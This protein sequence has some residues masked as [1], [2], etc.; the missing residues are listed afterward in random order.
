MRVRY[1]TQMKPPRIG[2]QRTQAPAVWVYVVMLVGLTYLNLLNGEIQ[3]G[4]IIAY[5]D[6]ALWS[7]TPH[8]GTQP[9]IELQHH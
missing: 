4:C 8:A 9:T 3:K 1:S 7:H 5:G 2:V 6:Q